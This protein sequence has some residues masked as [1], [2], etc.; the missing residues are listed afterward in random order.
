[1]Y[2][3]KPHTQTHTTPRLMHVIQ[4]HTQIYSHHIKCI[5]QNHTLKHTPRL[6]HVIQAHTQTYSHHTKCFLQ[7]HTHK[8]T[9]TPH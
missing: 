2:L 9:V 6:M 5:E 3:T 4:A 7:K 1:M 8:H